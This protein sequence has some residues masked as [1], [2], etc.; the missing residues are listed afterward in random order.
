VAGL[1]E[2]V[3][4]PAFDLPIRPLFIAFRDAYQRVDA[5][6]VSP[7]AFSETVGALPLDIHVALSR[8]VEATLAPELQSRA[9]AVLEAAGA[10]LATG[11]SI[12]ERMIGVSLQT[13]A[14]QLR[15]DA[16]GVEAA[17]KTR[18]QLQ[19]LVAAMSALTDYG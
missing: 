13:K 19:G 10:R 16:R 3:R 8:C 2:A 18:K 1:E 7:M 9:V 11:R 4:R 12:L 5:G 14:A 6:Q 15:D 17:S